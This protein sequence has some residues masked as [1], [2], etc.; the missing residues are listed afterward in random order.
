MSEYEIARSGSSQSCQEQNRI[1]QSKYD[2]SVGTRLGMLY[3]L[4]G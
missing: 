3:I 1:L 2:G 4:I